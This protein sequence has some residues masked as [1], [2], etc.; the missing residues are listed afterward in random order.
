MIDLPSLGLTIPQA[1]DLAANL[2]TIEALI[3]DAVTNEKTPL[4]HTSRDLHCITL[5]STAA[6]LNHLAKKL[7]D[8]TPTTPQP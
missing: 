8:I 7:Q 1:L 5:R 2:E 4:T 6:Q 3:C